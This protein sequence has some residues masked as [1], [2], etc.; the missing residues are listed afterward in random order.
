M[1]A[2]HDIATYCDLRWNTPS[3][4]ASVIGLSEAG[5]SIMLVCLLGVVRYS[6]REDSSALADHLEAVAR[7]VRGLAHVGEGSA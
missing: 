1:T 2:D 4:N 5:D 7:T 6:R 3:K